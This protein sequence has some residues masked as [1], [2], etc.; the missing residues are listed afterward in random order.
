MRKQ[1]QQQPK[2]QP[3]GCSAVS[4]LPSLRASVGGPWLTKQVRTVAQAQA[5]LWPLPSVSTTF[6]QQGVVRHVG[7]ITDCAYT[8]FVRHP[9]TPMQYLGATGRREPAGHGTSCT[10]VRDLDA[11][12]L[13]RLQALQARSA[14]RWTSTIEPV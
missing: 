14:L 3:Q 10:H 7:R 13:P 5:S 12:P 1:Q 9:D 2:A 4:R 11:P 8:T 6:F